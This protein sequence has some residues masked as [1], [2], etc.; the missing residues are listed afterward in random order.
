MKRIH[1][2]IAA[3]GAFCAMI[4][5][6]TLDAAIFGTD[7]PGD[8]ESTCLLLP[9]CS[10]NF[11]GTASSTPGGLLSGTLQ[12]GGS[13][14]GLQLGS[15]AEFITFGGGTESLSGFNFV[16]PL[17]FNSLYALTGGNNWGMPISGQQITLNVT[18]TSGAPLS[19]VTFYLEI[20]QSL[21][22]S[23]FTPQPDGITFGLFC[24]NLVTSCT[25]PPLTLV[26]TPTGPAGSILNPADVNPTTNTF[27]DLLRFTNV[28][29]A[30]GATGTFG[31]FI[32]DYKGT[33]QPSTSGSPASGSFNL[34]VVPSAAVPEPGSLWLGAAGVALLWLRK[35]TRR[36]S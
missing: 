33:R 16:G 1:L 28:N 4:G 19:A 12:R 14:L 21:I 11:I 3:Y 29:L 8:G 23:G 35:A 36:R 15:Q 20:P 24:S 9:T 10:S 26:S 6:S 32:S 27:G 5:A 22:T 34:E 13:T 2:A 25:P 18:N 30:P 7:V 17:G 31:F